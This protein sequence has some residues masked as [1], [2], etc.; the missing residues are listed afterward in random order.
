MLAPHELKNKAF[1]RS[2]K[3]Y[4]TQ[5]VDEYVE[6]LIEKYTELYKE[7]AEL[8]RKLRIV[9]TSYDEL[10]EEEAAIRGALVTARKMSDNIVKDASDRADVIVEAVR[11]RCDTVIKEFRSQLQ[12]EKDEMWEIR[13]RII[14]FKKSV[15]ELYGKHIEELQNLSVNE[16][17][18]IVLPDEDA[19]VAK[20]Y[21]SVRE[22]VEE[23]ALN[24][25]AKPAP[26]PELQQETAQAK[27]QIIDE[28]RMADG[29][30]PVLNEQTDNGD[31]K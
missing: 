15:Y 17:E 7:N 16:I 11:D 28:D 26:E 21:G 12:A 5:E 1:S 13:T 22:A 9:T 31:A 10:K 4:A 6:F 3:G 20:I 19:V 25:A 2:F 30:M 24:V 14:N 8:E 23:E 27:T 29:I 18:D